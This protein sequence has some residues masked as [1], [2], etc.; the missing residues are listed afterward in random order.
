MTPTVDS[1]IPLANAADPTTFANTVSSSARS[2]MSFADIC[3]AQLSQSPETHAVTPA[4]ASPATPS[5][6]PGNTAANPP[7]PKSSAKNAPGSSSALA[8]LV[9][10]PPILLPVLLDPLSGSPRQPAQNLPSSDSLNQDGSSSEEAIQATN[11]APP[12]GTTP[13]AVSTP[14][15]PGNANVSRIAALIP[16]LA[17]P[18]NPSPET[19]ASSAAPAQDPWSPS[20][21]VTTNPPAS[22]ASSSLS[23][24]PNGTAT[25]SSTPGAIPTD[26]PDDPASPDV[27]VAATRS[28]GPNAEAASQT[29]LPATA[30]QLPSVSLDR[31]TPVVP[32]DADQ[33]GTTQAHATQNSSCRRDASS[34]FSASGDPGCR[35]LI[36]STGA[37]Y[38]CGPES[39]TTTHDAAPVPARP[40][41]PTRFLSSGNIRDTDNQSRGPPHTSGDAACPFRRDIAGSGSRRFE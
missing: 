10:V 14:W 33:A 8:P 7:A 3:S 25:Q 27:I 26:A 32:G 21:Q 9:A 2:G 20:T 22:S 4:P 18:D 41:N 39:F 37:N 16:T 1:V 17:P 30:T 29:P 28:L 5:A 34:G 40:G 38:T 11:F 35:K 19:S 24:R 12:L 13:A 36:H 15:M 6:Q 31:Q 23:L